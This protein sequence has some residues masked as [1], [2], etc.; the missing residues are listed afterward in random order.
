[1]RKKLGRDQTQRERKCHLQ[2]R[3]PA[4]GEHRADKVPVSLRQE[5]VLPQ[6]ARGFMLETIVSVQ[7]RLQLALEP[8]QGHRKQS[9][10]IPAPHE[11]QQRGGGWSF[12]QR[13]RQ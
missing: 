11:L 4:A 12:W 3:Q 5:H 9:V 13:H 10:A 7:N 1:M 8:I 6:G 2:A